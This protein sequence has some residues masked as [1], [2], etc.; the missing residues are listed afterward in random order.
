MTPEEI[1]KQY[2]ARLITWD[3]M[4]TAL[5]QFG[6]EI[7]DQT[8]LEIYYLIPLDNT[9]PLNTTEGQKMKTLK[10][11]DNVSIIF[12]EWFDKLNGNTYY[13]ALVYIGDTS[14]EIPY[15]YGYNHGDKQA[16]DEALS[17]CG[18]RARVSSA[19]PFQ[20]YNHIRVKCIDKLK[21]D[22]IKEYNEG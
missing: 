8:G 1:L 6:F 16:I 3:E 5:N 18:Y 13:D 17:E 20:A 21:R 2:E 19:T 12:G 7:T 11:A 22:L 9:N 14:Y 10:K 4:Q 15:K